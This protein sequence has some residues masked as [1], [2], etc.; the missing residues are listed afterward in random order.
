MPAAGQEDVR[1][2]GESVEGREKGAGGSGH[3][4]PETKAALRPEPLAEAD[5]A[6][7]RG[8]HAGLSLGARGPQSPATAV[9]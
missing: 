5:P 2:T 8:Q 4:L 6:R 3:G 7:P 9:L 1:D